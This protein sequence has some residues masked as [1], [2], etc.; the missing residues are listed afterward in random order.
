MEL[1]SPE[2]FVIQE[3]GGVS[4]DSLSNTDNLTDAIC[5][6]LDECKKQAAIIDP[7][8]AASTNGSMDGNH[9]TINYLDEPSLFKRVELIDELF[10]QFH[11]AYFIALKAMYDSALLYSKPP[12]DRYTLLQSAIVAAMNHDNATPEIRYTLKN[13]LMTLDE[14]WLCL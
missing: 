1:N 7:Y 2:S 5:K 12:V 6:L 14:S 13:L 9:K 10:S 3:S 11:D 8:A 4:F